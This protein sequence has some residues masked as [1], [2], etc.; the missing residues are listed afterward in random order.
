MKNIII[1]IIAA[2]ISIG[3]ISC[4]SKVDQKDV[5]TS[6]P[7]INL[8]KPPAEPYSFKDFKL[9]M[10]LAE[11]K[12][13]K[14]RVTFKNNKKFETSLFIDTTIAGSGKQAYFLFREYGKGLQLSYISIQI[15]KADFPSVKE[16]LISKYGSPTSTSNI[17]K[18]NAM[19]ATFNGEKLIWNND[20]S[21][22]IAE[23]IGSKIDEADINFSHLRLGQSKQDQEDSAKAK[24]DI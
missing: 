18:S 14:P 9:G 8:P 16:A 12:N 24:K 20:T 22:I 3:L 19:G 2:L 11:F 7:K 10:T 15:P 23:S 4:D 1:V 21:E 6:P 5:A 17:V 13:L